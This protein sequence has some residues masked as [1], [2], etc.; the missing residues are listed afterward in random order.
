DDG[1]LGLFFG[2]D[3][4]LNL[5]YSAADHKSNTALVAGTWHHVCVVVAAGAATFY[6]DGVADG[7]AAAVLT[8]TPERIGDDTGSDSF[9]GW[10]DEVALYVSALSS[11]RVL[12]HLG[13]GFRGL[14]GLRVRLRRELHD[15]DAANYRWSANALA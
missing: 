7:T 10:L 4:K 8:F 5:R 11:A 15:E 12:A 3:F 2:S 14:L 6:V 1:T 13:A 9:K